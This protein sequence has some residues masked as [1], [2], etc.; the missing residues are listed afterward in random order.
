MEESPI[1]L[2]AGEG[3]AGLLAVEAVALDGGSASGDGPAADHDD[4]SS[5]R[6]VAVLLGAAAIAAAVVGALA[7][8]LTSDASDAWNSAVRT[9]LKRATAAMEDVR[10]VYQAEFP[11]AI[12]VMSARA[13]AAG[14]AAAASADP[15]NAVAYTIAAGGQANAA[16][17]L[18]QSVP[19]VTDPKYALPNGGVDLARRLADQRAQNAD[20]V[21][22]DPGAI[23]AQG[24][25]LAAKA[26]WLLLAL[27]P[28]GACAL[29]GTL[30]QAF[31][32][33]RPA[34]LGVGSVLLGA[35]VIAA[36]AAEVLA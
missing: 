10:Y 12:S 27:I 16:S 21:A 17:A 5:H 4:G 22:L 18:E 23:Q 30:A 35:G 2:A 29:F 6:G 33:W 11:Q 36:I 15:G 19:L 20:L 32:R 25:A 26:H 31:R 24:D 7:S 14:Y 8:G 13:Q 34:L 1:G 3:T 9:E 28:L